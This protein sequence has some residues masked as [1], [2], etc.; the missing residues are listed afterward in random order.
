MNEQ[1]VPSDPQNEASTN[2]RE[3]LTNKIQT[4]RRQTVAPRKLLLLAVATVFCLAAA[5]V[6]VA[7]L[8]APAG[9]KNV[10]WTRY[11]HDL[12]NSRFQNVDEINTSNAPRLR[13]AWVFHTGVLDP[14][15][16]LETSPIEVGGSLF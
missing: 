7:V 14:A 1:R 5:A 10:E 13:V 8:A 3:S 15:S 6:Y 11:G 2:T 4:G 16:E 12:A 9:K